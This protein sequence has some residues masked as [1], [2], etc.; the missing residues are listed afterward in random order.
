MER[1][2]CPPPA[3]ALLPNPSLLALSTVKGEEL[4]PEIQLHHIPQFCR[5]HPMGSLISPF[6]G[7]FRVDP[8]IVCVV[9]LEEYKE[10][11]QPERLSTACVPAIGPHWG[12]R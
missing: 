8:R 9:W 11:L 12:L 2:W 5:G 1:E 6:F 7:V 10:A 4:R 3:P